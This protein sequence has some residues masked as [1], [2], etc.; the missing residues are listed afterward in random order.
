MIWQN[1]HW[2]DVIWLQIKIITT[3]S[4]AHAQ[5]IFICSKSTKETVKNKKNMCK[6]KNK[7]TRT[8]QFRTTK[9]NTFLF[10]AA[11]IAYTGK[12]WNKQEHGPEMSDFLSRYHKVHQNY[13]QLRFSLRWNLWWNLESDGFGIVSKYDLEFSG[14]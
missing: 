11:N 1:C 14:I 9:F 7:N 4:N 3:G 5:Q 2:H 13:F 12:R 8:T 6:V 10:P